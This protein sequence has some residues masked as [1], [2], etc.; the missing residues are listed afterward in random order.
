VVEFIRPAYFVPEIKPIDELLQELRARRTHVA[1]VAD[2][3]GGL[4]GVVTLEDML[5]ELVGEIADEFDPGYEPY[6]EVEPHV[7]DVDGRVSLN[8]M[9][10]VLDIDRDEVKPVDA[11]S[12]GGLISELLER[13]PEEGDVVETGPLRLEVRAMDGYRV[14]LARVERIRHGNQTAATDD[15]TESGE[16]PVES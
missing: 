9:F 2:E 7:Y 11:E 4:A 15:S 14:A 3:Y 6:R 12:V 5:E 16:M 13:I 8:D 10:D 1:I